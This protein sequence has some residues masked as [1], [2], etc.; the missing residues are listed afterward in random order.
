[1]KLV[2]KE[3]WKQNDAA[4]P[5]VY[6][7]GSRG[8]IKR[9]ESS[10]SSSCKFRGLWPCACVS[11]LIVS[12]ASNLLFDMRTEHFDF[13]CSR[14]ETFRHPHASDHRMQNSEGACTENS[15]IPE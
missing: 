15:P 7:H 14:S 3:H 8:V 11:L 13:D 6:V 1:M 5:G 4:P 10:S 9:P 12:C 2:A